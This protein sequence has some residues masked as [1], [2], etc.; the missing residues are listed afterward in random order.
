MIGQQGPILVTWHM[1]G[2]F[3]IEYHSPA[4]DGQHAASFEGNIS[5]SPQTLTGHSTFEIKYVLIR[6][7]SFVIPRVARNCNVFGCEEN[8]E[9]IPRSHQEG[10]MIPEFQYTNL[11]SQQSFPTRSCN[12]EAHESYI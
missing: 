3:V 1:R 11:A 10:S 6:P 2:T 7:M 5:A 9:T 8:S 12:W 4:E